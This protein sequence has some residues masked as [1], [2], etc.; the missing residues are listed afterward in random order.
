MLLNFF[1]IA[2]AIES[3][4]SVPE[5]SSI[6]DSA[7]ILGSRGLFFACAKHASKVKMLSVQQEQPVYK[8]N[9]TLFYTATDTDQYWSMAALQI[10]E[11]VSR[12][13]SC[14]GRVGRVAQRIQ[15]PRSL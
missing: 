13:V 9:M 1:S 8:Q 4:S 7:G 2:L 10:A 15:E 11:G 14:Q 12:S 6:A 5:I 3:S